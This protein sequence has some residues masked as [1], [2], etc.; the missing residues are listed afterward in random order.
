MTINKS[1]SIFNKWIVCILIFM[2]CRKEDAPLPDNFLNFETNAIGINSSESEITVTVKCSRPVDL[3]IPFVIQTSNINAE[4]GIDYTSEPA[5]SATGTINLTIPATGDKTSFK[6]KKIPGTLYDGDEQVNFE[7]ASATS[8]IIIG[9][10]NRLEVTFGELIS[11]GTSMTL[12]GGGATYPNKVFVDLSANRQTSV[13][14][15][16]WDLGFYTGADDFR[17]ILNSSVNMMVKQINKNDLNS[18]TASDTIGFSTDVIF[19]QTN[20]KVEQLEYIDY[21][22]GDLSKTA[23]DQ[24]S[25]NDA[26]NKVYI[27]N[28]GNGIGV[29]AA[30]RGWKK[31][32]VIRNNSGGYTLQ[33]ADI[34]ATSF[35]TV[36]I[37]KTESTFFQYT[38]FENGRIDVD[39]DK[40]KWDM[41][42]TYFANVTNFGSGEVPYMF[43]DIILINR[44]IQV[45]KVLVADKAFADFS[46]ADIASQTFLSNQNV[47]GSDWR[48]GGSPFSQPAVKTDR[49]YIIKD[50][51]NNYYKVRFTALT[52][53]GE[54][55]YPAFESVLV[56]AGD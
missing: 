26:D 16:N 32:R 6:I 19:S 20:P 34:S 1:M 36:D 27:V 15:T 35:S 22:D 31:I 54:R 55:G 39:P 52:Q 42:W 48:S 37:D 51:D 21:P 18:V 11:A 2:S 17:V 56:K 38:S 3:D 47:I 30:S 50:S 14:R 9:S 10:L 13:N 29:G 8:P 53:A 25:A 40:T 7:I 45:A 49:Y 24:V 28:R 33:Y 41:T 46:E 23:I 44:N 43:Q 12:E 4:Y 5:A